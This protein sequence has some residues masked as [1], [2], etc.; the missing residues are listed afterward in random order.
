MDT[1]SINK[2][3]HGAPKPAN[4]IAGMV[5]TPPVDCGLKVGDE[6]TYSNDYGAVFKGKKVRGFTSEVTSWGACVYF[7]PSDCW[8]RPVD[9]ASLCRAQGEA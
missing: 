9:P 1:T 7:E 8:W 2:P 6:V 3:I 5:T 4:V